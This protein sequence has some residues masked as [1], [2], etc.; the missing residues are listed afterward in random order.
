MYILSTIEFINLLTSF[1]A[2]YGLY[3]IKIYIF[4]IK[5]LEQRR[6]GLIF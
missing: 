6:P 5:K 1:V 2:E 3:N 4:L